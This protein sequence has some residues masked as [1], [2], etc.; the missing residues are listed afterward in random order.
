[1]IILTILLAVAVAV[2]LVVLA[3]AGTV[4]IPVLDVVVGVAII[5]LVVKAFKFIFGRRTPKE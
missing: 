1:M 4:L 5:G 2:L 3:L